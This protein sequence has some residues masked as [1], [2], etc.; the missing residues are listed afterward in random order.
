MGRVRTRRL[1]MT[2]QTRIPA[3][4]RKSNGSRVRQSRLGL[5]AC[6]LR[7]DRCALHEPSL[8][9]L[10]VC[11]SRLLLIFRLT[12]SRA[13]LREICLRG[14]VRRTGGVDLGP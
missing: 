3:R 9:L 2:W 4:S 11:L 10:D 8:R 5:R 1:A 14:L 12:E 13:R 7:G 6:D